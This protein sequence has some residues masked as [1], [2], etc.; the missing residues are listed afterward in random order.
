MT[1]ARFH[2]AATMTGDTVTLRAAM[3]VRNEGK[4]LQRC[5]DSIKDHIDH[6]TI[7]DTGS[8]DNTVEV[9][10]AYLKDNPGNLYFDEWVDF[11]HNRSKSL[12]YDRGVARFTLVIDADEILQDA[13]GLANLGDASSYLTTVT[14]GGEGWWSKRI[15]RDDLNFRYEPE[16]HAVP[17]TDHPDVGE[18]LEGV[19]IHHFNDGGCKAGRMEWLV[20]KLEGKD[21]TRSVFYLANT[22]R[23]MGRYADALPHFLKRA[24]M[25]G[26]EEEAWYALYRAGQMQALTGDWASAVKTLEDAVARRPGRLEPLYA[27]ATGHR[28]RGERAEAYWATARGTNRPA[29]TD[30]LFVARWIWD[31]GMLF[32]HSISSFWMGKFDEALSACDTLLTL[33]LPEAHRAQTLRNRQFTLDAMKV[34]S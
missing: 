2:A 5:L 8:T 32:E 13:S 34:A 3:I 24:E 7:V 9:I 12:E 31:Y 28:A 18:R 4:V 21:D 33:D 27:L 1:A 23:D 11:G 29:S 19:T 16:V 25:G 26:W 6:L 15:L 22:L 10:E 17:V 14:A 20:S 30:S